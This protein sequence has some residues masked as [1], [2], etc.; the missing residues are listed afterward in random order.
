MVLDK[1]FNPPDQQPPCQTKE[2][3]THYRKYGRP[4]HDALPRASASQ[5]STHRNLPLGASPTAR[6]RTSV[7]HQGSGPQSKAV[8]D[9]VQVLCLLPTHHHHTSNNTA[10]LLSKVTESPRETESL[11][12][13]QKD[14]QQPP[15][16]KP[17]MP[18]SSSSIF[19]KSRGCDP[20]AQQAGQL[21]DSSSQTWRGR[22]DGPE[23]W[24]T[25][26]L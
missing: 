16:P 24:P 20:T 14:P 21:P 10:S 3:T 18:L 1:L 4:D 22:G 15:V 5:L 2:D 13:H 23:A 6:A 11:K 9:R 17:N 26:V 7:A 8:P 25:D 19:S 12:G